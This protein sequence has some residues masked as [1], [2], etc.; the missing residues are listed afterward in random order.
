[1]FRAVALVAVVAF[2][3]A[4]LS[5]AGEQPA[6]A[7]AK[8]KGSI[9][10]VKDGKAVARIVIAGN[11]PRYTQIAALELQTYI[12]KITGAR[13]QITTDELPHAG[14]GY[15][16]LVGE[17]R[18]T[19]ELGYSS[20]DFAKDELLVETR[21]SRLILMGRDEPEYGWVTYEENGHWP[22]FWPDAVNGGPDRRQIYK[23][24]GSLSAVYEFLEKFCG[25]RWYMVTE[26]GE[27]VPSRKTLTFANIHVR[28]RPWCRIRKF[29]IE[30]PSPWHFYES[31]GAKGSPLGSRAIHTLGPGHKGWRKL[32]MWLERMR[33]GG[34]LY[35]N[36]H[37]LYSYYD[38]FGKQHPDWFA[39]GDASYGNQLCYSNPQVI[40]QVAK[41]ICDYF[42][43]KYPEGRYPNIDR[44]YWITAAGD[45]HAVVPMDN[46][47]FCKCP[48]CRGKWQAGQDWMFFGGRRSDYIWGFVNEVARRVA[49][50]HPDKFVSALAYW[51]YTVPPSFAI[52]K[53]VAVMY[54]KS[55]SQ[56]GD[57][58]RKAFD[59]KWL[60]QWRKRTRHLS[61]W[62][63]YNFPRGAVFP[64]IQPHR[65]AEDMK[66]LRG[67]PIDGM[68]I[69]L[70]SV[71]PAMEHINL[72]CAMKL[73]DDPQ[74]DIDQLLD[75]YYRLFYGPAEKPMRR[76]FEKIESIF[77]SEKN[78][79][80]VLKQGKEHLDAKT[81]W[82]VMCPP[83][84][85]AEF[86]KLIKKAYR[87]V[88]KQ[89]PYLDRVKLMDLAIYG[90]M[91]RCSQ[92][93]RR[94]AGRKPPQ[95]I[96]PQV[97]QPPV[98]DGLLNDAC[99]KQAATTGEFKTIKGE[100]SRLKTSARLGCDAGY[101][102]VAV[103]CKE[104][105]MDSITA[106]CR[107]R[108]GNVFE[109]DCIEI[110]LDPDRS[111]RK[112]YQ[113]VFNTLGTLS[114]AAWERGAGKDESWNPSVR[115]EVVKEQNGWTAEAAIPLADL[116]FKGIPHGAKWGVN[117]CRDRLRDGR[118]ELT[119]WSPTLVSWH[120][121]QDF[122]VAVF[123]SNDIRV[124][125][126]SE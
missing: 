35:A 68:F 55:V 34:V 97:S 29:N 120:E 24:H 1:M 46:D 93:Y 112:Y 87:A 125:L 91:V 86:G 32:F 14:E 124:G 75:E 103:E 122:A 20:D 31:Y 49:R 98:I 85:L 95:V 96:I 38:R 94:H 65:I 28:R 118:W 88:G 42:E 61:I 108:D 54:C 57:P 56:Y 10:L 43:G 73:L 82:E 121:L 41:D 45:F 52:E 50:K 51:Q 30:M 104:P 110:F 53:N 70:D 44:A 79:R 9:A 76:F 62:E 26:I 5:V 109:D 4:C 33:Y 19:R 100:K 8:G 89:Q 102:Y 16:V 71:N 107:T 81:S 92:D 6:D 7:S 90:H 64:G 21:G 13:L 23:D 66:F 40:E 17:S 58:R 15:C 101:L 116:G 117:I 77:T 83:E 69:E 114:D 27:V 25:V 72:Y 48:R 47:Q 119:A 18:L 22:G 63:Y 106:L 123:P 78:W 80:S 2:L 115:V 60:P 59:R 113:V 99:W 11:P 67:L 39:N 84:T 74:I 3:T 36:N 126:G 105:Q 12:E 111:D 37:S